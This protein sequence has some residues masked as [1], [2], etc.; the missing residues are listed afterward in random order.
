MI[1]RKAKWLTLMEDN[2]KAVEIY[3]HSKVSRKQAKEAGLLFYWPGEPCKN[4]HLTYR[5][6]SSCICRQCNL[7]NLAEYNGHLDQTDKNLKKK[8]DLLFEKELRSIEKD[9]DYLD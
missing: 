7:D 5:Y 4:G 2:R 9:F 6:T 3:G 1:K 8:R